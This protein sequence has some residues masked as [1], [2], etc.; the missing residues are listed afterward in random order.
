M[1]ED[2]AEMQEARNHGL[3]AR[4]E[5]RL[6]RLPDHLRGDEPCQI[7]GTENNIVWFTDSPF[8]NY[9]VRNNDPDAK[10][11]ILCISCFVKLVDVKGLHVTGWHLTPEWHW[12]TKAQHEAR[13]EIG[14]R[15]PE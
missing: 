12:E 1:A 10:D 4:H 14:S 5:T 13:R 9:V 3:K 7:C 2:R 11:Q 15:D 6:S 8:W